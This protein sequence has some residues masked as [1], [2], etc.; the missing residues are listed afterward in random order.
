MRR[1]IETAAKA[2]HI[3]PPEIVDEEEHDVGRSLFILGLGCGCATGQNSC[4]ESENEEKRFVVHAR[5]IGLKRWMVD[6][7]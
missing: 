1:L 3:T 7:G 6:L 2:S 4:H 5:L